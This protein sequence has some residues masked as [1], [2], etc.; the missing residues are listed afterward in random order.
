MITG[1]IMASGYSRRMGENKLLLEEYVKL[2][3]SKN[4]KIIFF[5]P[6]YTD[7]YKERMQKSY[8]EEL[9]EFTNELS[10]KYEAKV[11]DMMNVSLPDSCFSDYANV[12]SIGAVKIASYIN[13]VI[14]G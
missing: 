5:I 4:L 14:D 9:L 3:K 6:P 7:W 11:V 12:N 13:E 2:C 10:T 8:Y 1:I